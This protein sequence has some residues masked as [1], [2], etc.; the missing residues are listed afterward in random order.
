VAD[1]CRA[2]GI[3]FHLDAAQ[4]AGM[5]PVDFAALGCDSLAVSG[6]KWIGGPL[7][8]GVLC[9]RRARQE[10]LAPPLVG[11]YSGDLDANGRF[12][13]NAG[14]VRYEYGTRNVAAALGLAEAMRL[15]ERIGRDRIAARGRQLAARAHAGLAALPGVEILSP[16]GGELAAAMVTF[17]TARIPH[18]RLFGLLLREKSIRAR[19]VT[20]E[21]LNA[22][23]VSTHLCNSPAQIDA[24]VAAVGEFLRREA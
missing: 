13:L 21:K 16:D 20:E 22:L 5:V 18:D 2:R 10:E 12:A 24:L 15:Q 1:L 14:A 11:A 8:T 7:E 4:S 3:W 19:P 6:H 17:R 23:R 9:V